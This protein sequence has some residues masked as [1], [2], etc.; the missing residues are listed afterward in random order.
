MLRK[1]KKAA[2]THV[3]QDSEMFSQFSGL[4]NVLASACAQIWLQVVLILSWPIRVTEWSCMMLMLCEIISVQHQGLDERASLSFWLS[5]AAFLF[6]NT[7]FC[8]D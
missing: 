3:H 2:V 7:Y 6:L 1:K 8:S 5:G 4:D